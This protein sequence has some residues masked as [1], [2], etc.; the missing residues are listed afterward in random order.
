MTL[1]DW[2]EIADIVIAAG[3]IGSG[4][5]SLWAIRKSNWNSAM[6]TAP[7]ITIKSNFTL[8]MTDNLSGGWGAI[9]GRTIGQ[10][11]GYIV[12]AMTFDFK[13]EGRG[14]ALN[15]EKVK[16]GCPFALANKESYKDVPSILA[17]GDS[18]QRSPNMR[19]LWR[20]WYHGWAKKDLPINVSLTYT[21]DQDNIKCISEWSGFLH[22]FEKGENV[23][24]MK[25]TNEYC[26]SQTAIKYKT[27]SWLNKIINARKIS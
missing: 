14:V 19:I 9:N 23:L 13:N 25:P 18:F 21:N 8:G 12:V 15:I 1:K 24:T 17:P 27:I 22:P 20:D 10:Y 16:V 5:L 2:S 3:A 26:S 11:T 6:S 7:V 4:F